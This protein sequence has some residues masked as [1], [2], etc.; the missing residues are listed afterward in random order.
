MPRL[1]HHGAILIA[2]WF[3]T[4]TSPVL[5]FASEQGYSV[6]RWGVEEGLPNNALSGVI[7]SR[8]GYLWIATWA[9]AVRFDGAR[10]NAHRRS[11]P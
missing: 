1:L 10:F 6:D 11:A 8:D 3:L 9:G 2:L 4:L 7:Q 5:T